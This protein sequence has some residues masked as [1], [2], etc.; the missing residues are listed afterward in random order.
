MQLKKGDR[1]KATHNRT[2]D[3]STFTVERVEDNAYY[4]LVVVSESG[5]RFNSTE[6]SFEKLVQP[7]PSTFGQVFVATQVDDVPVRH[8]VFVDEDAETGLPLHRPI[9]IDFAQTLNVTAW[10]ESIPPVMWELVPDE[11]EEFPQPTPEP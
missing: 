7:I 8:L 6:W 3:Q 4:G 1:V 11:E 5:M 10:D 2:K 9:H